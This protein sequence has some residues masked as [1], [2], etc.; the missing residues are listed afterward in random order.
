MNKKFSKIS[1]MVAIVGV[2]LSITAIII[3]LLAY[4]KPFHWLSISFLYNLVV[5]TVVVIVC[6]LGLLT[7]AIIYILKTKK[8]TNLFFLILSIFVAVITLAYFLQADYITNT[9]I[10]VVFIITWSL[11]L[12]AYLSAIILLI[13]SK[14]INK[15]LSKEVN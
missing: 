8:M 13:I 1:S 11:S 4:E 14:H 2:V 10:N 15:K 5:W 12:A 3:F 7:V 6:T 9:H